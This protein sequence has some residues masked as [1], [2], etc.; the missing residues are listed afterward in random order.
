MTKVDFKKDSQEFNFFMD[1]WNHVKS[2]YM[3]DGKSDRYWEGLIASSSAIHAKYGR[4]ETKIG[5]LAKHLLCAF[6][7]FC[8]AEANRRD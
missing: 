6:N 1:F 2:Y 4:S 3:V 8:E 7:D 5:R